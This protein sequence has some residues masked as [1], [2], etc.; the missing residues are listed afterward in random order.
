[1]IAPIQ[2]HWLVEW[3]WNICVYKYMCMFSCVCRWLPLWTTWLFFM[4]NEGSTRKQSLCVKGHWR[5]ERRWV[6]GQMNESCVFFCLNLSQP[7]L[8][9]KTSHI[10]SSV[11]HLTLSLS[12]IHPCVFQRRKNKASILESS[13]LF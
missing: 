1:M 7:V 3:V 5:S 6:R 9:L 12:F 2:N 13:D 8:H 11:H 4:A 10:L